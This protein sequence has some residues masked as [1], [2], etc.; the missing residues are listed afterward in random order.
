[1]WDSSRLLCSFCFD[2]GDTRAT[3]AL[4]R[5]MMK[6]MSVRLIS[7]LWEKVLLSLLR[8]PD[9]PS[10]APP[11]LEGPLL[12]GFFVQVDDT[13]RN[14]PLRSDSPSVV[15]GTLGVFHLASINASRSQHDLELG[16][17]SL[18]DGLAMLDRRAIN[19]GPDL[20]AHLKLA[21]QM[22]VVLRSE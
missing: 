14:S 1:M 18:R 17:R 19:V 16:C 9:P 20:Q 22:M 2:Q 15:N 8:Y 7:T 21:E 6:S 11:D 10:A 5:S 13:F 3:E 12:Q 4:P